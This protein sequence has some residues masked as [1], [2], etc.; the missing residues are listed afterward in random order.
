MN[1]ILRQ[2]TPAIRGAYSCAIMKKIVGSLCVLICITCFAQSPNAKVLVLEKEQGE[3]RVRPAG[4]GIATLPVEFTLKVTPQNSGSQHLILGTQ[5]IPPG[6]TVPKHRHLDQDEV[7]FLQSGKARFTLN[8]KDYEVHDGGMIFAPSNT[9]M[10]LE[11]IGTDDI[12]LIF[13]YSAPGFEEY[14]RCTSAPAGQTA[15]QLSLDQLRACAR[16]GDV[17]YEGL[18]GTAKK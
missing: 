8:G 6:G 18:T 3:K 1:A 7:V 9:W 11:N 14:M 17:E 15:P 2:L 10:A 12:Q 13:I 5:T 16:K 4:A